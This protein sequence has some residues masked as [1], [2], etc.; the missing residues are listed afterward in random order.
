MFCARGAGAWRCWLLLQAEGTLRSRSRIGATLIPPICWPPME[1][2]A[3]A[4][5]TRLAF[6]SKP[7]RAGSHCRPIISRKFSAQ[8]WPAA[9]DN[10]SARRPFGPNSNVA[11]KGQPTCALREGEDFERGNG[12]WCAEQV[13]LWP[14]LRPQQSAGF[15]LS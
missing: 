10:T 8:N 5:L 13:A 4:P 9:L 12:S 1:L 15:W 6:S 2:R 14:S 11:H 3:L 7:A